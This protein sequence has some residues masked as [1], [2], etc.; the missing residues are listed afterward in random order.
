[1]NLI[2][3]CMNFAAAQINVAESVPFLQPELSG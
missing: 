1:M 3:L 2:L